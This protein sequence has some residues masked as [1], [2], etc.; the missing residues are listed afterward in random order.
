MNFQTASVY[1]TDDFIDILID[2]LID[3]VKR[4]YKSNPDY[5]YRGV[6]V[7][8]SQKCTV[9]MHLTNSR[10]S[11]DDAMSLAVSIDAEGPFMALTPTLVLWHVSF[12]TI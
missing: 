12:D 6:E 10:T 11:N 8:T 9:E 3:D 7:N 5:I 2:I 1:L 4:D